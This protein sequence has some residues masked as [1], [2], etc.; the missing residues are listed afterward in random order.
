MT[1]N[2]ETKPT[3]TNSVSDLKT[4]KVITRPTLSTTRLMTFGVGDITL[5]KLWGQ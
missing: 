5:F 1:N 4:A 2:H 3:T